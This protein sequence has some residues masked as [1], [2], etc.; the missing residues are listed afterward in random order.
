MITSG[1]LATAV[2]RGVTRGS[3]P[4]ATS[5]LLITRRNLGD[6]VRGPKFEDLA[7]NLKK[8]QQFF[9]KDP[10]SY[11]EYKQ[12]CVSLRP[13]AFGAVVVGCVL[14]LII[15]PPKSSYWA[16][17]GPGGLYYY[18]KDR[19]SPKSPPLFLTKK[20]DSDIDVAGLVNTH[21]QEGLF[22]KGQPKVKKAP[23]VE[24][25]IETAKVEPAPVAAAKVEE[26]QPIQ[27]ADKHNAFVFIKPHAITDKVKGL[28]DDKLKS[29]GI[30]V[31]SSGTIVAD[32][33]DEE[34]L[35]DTH[36]GAIA[37]RA[38][39][40]K[41]DELTVQPKAQEAFE[42]AFGMKWTD[43]VKSGQVYNAMDAAKKLGLSSK[44][45]GAK[46]DKLTKDVDLLKFGGGFYCAQIDGIYVINAFYMS[47]REKFTAPGTSIYYY[48]VQWNPKDLSWGDFRE[49][50]LGGTDP[51][52]A[53]SDSARHL[54]YKN[55]ES[56]G[57]EACPYTG[58]NGVHASASPF[59]ALSERCNWLGVK[60][61]EDYFG[62]ALLAKGVP[63][64]M[65]KAWCDDPSVSFD[66]KKQSLFDLLEDLDAGDCLNKSA[67]I[68]DA[69]K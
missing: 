28:L 55:W 3:P 5:A 43:A 51:K 37:N 33:I 62:K 4:V 21:I 16:T 22:G 1:L 56:L 9:S 52:I 69:N 41:A 15:D 13:L 14:A 42:K 8:A 68:A 45:L 54:I 11:P 19:F 30:E 26:A 49:K 59:E 66:G 50:V 17:Y 39:K 27:G 63:L 34:K 60:L 6:T 40:L 23:K 10:I 67:S 58:D 29:S 64:N 46:C 44:E 25:V 48:D 20:A 47:M 38:V 32:R 31:L 57:L 2:R 36:Y 53:Y 7:A 65:L 35:I 24:E 18:V 12:Q 61:D